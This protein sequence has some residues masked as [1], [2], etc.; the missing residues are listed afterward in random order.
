MHFIGL[1]LDLFC[2]S[3]AR[4]SGRRG[5]ALSALCRPTLLLTV[6][7]LGIDTPLIY[8]H[9]AAPN[10]PSVGTQLYITR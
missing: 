10:P 1:R 2:C 3:P 4:W 6:V 9:P 5:V 7:S 8:F